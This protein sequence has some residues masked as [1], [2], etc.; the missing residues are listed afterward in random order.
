MKPAKNASY[1][2]AW[3]KPVKTSKDSPA[4]SVGQ[5]TA[6]DMPAGPHKMPMGKPAKR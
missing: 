3:E 1:E 5:M 2:K 6:R 4:K